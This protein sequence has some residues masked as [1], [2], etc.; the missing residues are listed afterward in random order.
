M[1][2]SVAQW[3]IQSI[4]KHMSGQFEDHGLP[5]PMQDARV[6]ACDLLG[7]DLTDLITRS[8][9]TL[10]TN[11]SD[12]LLSAVERRLAGE[13]VHRILGHREFYGLDLKLCD[14]T[15]EPR[16]DTETLVEAALPFLRNRVATK[17]QATLLDLGTGTGAVCLALLANEPR[18]KGEG[19]DISADALAMA[20]R[21]AT[22]LGLADRFGT[23][24][25]DW[26]D[27][28]VDSYDLI[29]SN[30][31]YIRSGDIEG[32]AVEVK[33]FDPRAALDGGPDGLQAYR[34]IAQNSGDHLNEG[35][36][37]MVETGFDQHD[38][39]IALMADQGWNCLSRQRDL[40]GQDRV[41]EFGQNDH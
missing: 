25:S 11:E 38:D 21:N 30:P 3:S 22:R 29:V 10:S 26:F 31:P 24:E 32:L 14:A 39:V 27:R 34:A 41:L 9:Q 15:L 1:A 18:A 7:F 37:I 8:D 28:V 33:A 36:R 20:Q 17:G 5:T 35:G 23:L 12:R 2:E 13:P 4:V 16:P 40:N 6:L 19:T